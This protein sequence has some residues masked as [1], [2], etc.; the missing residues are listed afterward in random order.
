MQPFHFESFIVNYVVLISAVILV[1]L[2]W[3][4]IS[5]SSLI[6]IAA[7]SILLGV[8]EIQLPAGGFAQS[9]AMK[10]DAIPVLMKLKGLPAQ[11]GSD[12]AVVFSPKF[13]LMQILPTWTSHATLLAIGS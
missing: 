13:E 8:V 6:W 7:L 1:A 4:N 10:D 2:I 11:N 12:P 5:S 3:K 9:D